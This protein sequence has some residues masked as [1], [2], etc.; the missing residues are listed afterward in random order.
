MTDLRF[1]LHG[2]PKTKKNS[3][4]IVRVGRYSK[5]LP[6]EAF[7]DYQKTCLAQLLQ[8]RLC[9]LGIRYPV[10]VKALYYMQT[11]R[12]VDLTNLNESLH[13]I[14]VGAGVLADD[15][16]DIIATTDGSVVL[17]DKGNPRVEITITAKGPD[18]SQWKNG[19]E[20]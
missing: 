11:R 7:E 10:N 12:R 17:Y 2:D 3:P 1:T 9:H 8:R 15:N 6:S 18:Y 19:G 5:V 4:R 20:V 16:R 14:L 13:D